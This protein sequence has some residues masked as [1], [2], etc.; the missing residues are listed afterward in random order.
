MMHVLLLTETLR[1]IEYYDRPTVYFMV[2]NGLYLIDFC[3]QD[4]ENLFDYKIEI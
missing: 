3:Y 1:N 4:P 2:G